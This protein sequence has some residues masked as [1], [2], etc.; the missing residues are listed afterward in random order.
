MM[1]EKISAII[2]EDEDAAQKALQSYIQKFC[3]QVE[4]VGHANDCRQA[5][6]VI[7][8][9]Q[10]QLVFLDVEMPFGNAFDVFL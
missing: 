9:L 1:L 7:H 8:R 3:P 5:I 2:V 10:P 4:L 6:E